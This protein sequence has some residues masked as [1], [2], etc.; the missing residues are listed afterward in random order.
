M[1]DQ[2]F[3]P[4]DDF[5][6]EGFLDDRDFAGDDFAQAECTQADGEAIDDNFFAAEEELIRSLGEL[7]T[8]SRSF[9]K[10]VVGTAK[11]A[12]QSR[13][14]VRRTMNAAMVF[15][16]LTA[17][18][19]WN[20]PGLLVEGFRSDQMAEHRGVFR[21]GE[22]IE[23]DSFIDPQNSLLAQDSVT[24]VQEWSLVEAALRERKRQSE[25]VHVI[26]TVG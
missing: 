13:A 16:A 12:Q 4:D 19:Q 7:P 21:P 3:M 8:L 11:R 9:R 6:P 26:D 18:A 2:N 22:L 1:T 14:R 10:R 20:R 5:G 23:H 17:V 25:V 24:S 15:L